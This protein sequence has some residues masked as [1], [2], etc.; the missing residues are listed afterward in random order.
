MELDPIQCA[1]FIPLVNLLKLSAS[2]ILYTLYSIILQ[3]VC[4]VSAVPIPDMSLY[5]Y[6]ENL[7]TSEYSRK[8]FCTVVKFTHFTVKV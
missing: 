2:N 3:N 8:T 5:E 7:K 1:I 6:Y 4:N